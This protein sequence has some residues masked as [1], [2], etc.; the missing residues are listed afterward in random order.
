MAASYG[1]FNTS[2]VPASVDIMGFSCRY[3]MLCC[4]SLSLVIHACPIHF[5]F[6]RSPEISNDGLFATGSKNFERQ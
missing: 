6:F 1:N 3:A 4:S 2:A 5:S